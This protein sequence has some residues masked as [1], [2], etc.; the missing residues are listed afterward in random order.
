MP[1]GLIIFF[2][3]GAWLRHILWP[4]STNARDYRSVHIQSR[5]ILTSDHF[6]FDRN[7]IYCMTIVT[8]CDDV[9]RYKASSAETKL[10]YICREHWMQR[11]TF[12]SETHA[13]DTHS[14]TDAERHNTFSAG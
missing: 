3:K 14:V 7:D 10:N 2:R 12:A 9:L 6:M 13:A 1:V 5:V 11:I 4:I 8:L